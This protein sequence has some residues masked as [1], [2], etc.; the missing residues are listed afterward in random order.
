MQEWVVG[1]RRGGRCDGVV[2]GL[3]VGT[4]MGDRCDGVVHG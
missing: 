2:Y 3:V 1:T 4:R